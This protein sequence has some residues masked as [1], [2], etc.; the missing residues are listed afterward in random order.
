MAISDRREQV[1]EYSKI[2]LD[3]FK[4]FVTDL[5]PLMGDPAFKSNGMLQGL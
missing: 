4:V 5:K 2:I 3:N 1:G